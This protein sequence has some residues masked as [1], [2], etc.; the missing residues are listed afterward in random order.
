MN[1][2]L[3]KRVLFMTFAVMGILT[4]NGFAQS[5]NNQLEVEQPN[6][7]FIFIDD[8]GYSD[9]SSY[10]NKEMETPH[11]DRLAKEGIKFTNGYVPAP[12]C[13][14]SR[15]GAMTGQYPARWNIYSFLSQ[16]ENNNRKGMDDYLSL[17]APT[18]ART[19]KEAGYATGHFGKWHMGG[20]RDI[21]DA[22]L[23]TEYGFDQTLVSFEGLGDRILIKDHGLSNASAELGMGNI[24]WAEKWEHTGIWVDST[25]AFIER[26]KDTQPFY[27]NLWPGDVHDPFIPNPEWR[28]KFS[29]FDNDQHKRDFYATLWNLDNEV[30]RLLDKLDELGLS[31]NTLIILMSDNGPTD[32]G[33]YYRDFYWPPGDSDPFYGRK[34][35]L[36]EGGIRVPF[37]ARWPGEIP[38]G[39]TDTSTIINAIDLFP[40]VTKMA[41]VPNH[42]LD[43]DGE[44]MSQALKGVSMKR[45]KPL[46]WEYGRNE[47]F[48]YPG[49]PRF[50]S[51]NLAMRDGDWKLLINDDGSEVELYNLV[52][53]PAETTNLAEENPEKRD[54]L[55]E[56]IFEWRRSLP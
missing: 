7:I 19:M 31:E 54:R 47:H 17:D 26:Y 18:I 9:L 21:N 24:Q 38:A 28:E 40:T 32:W 49:N 37:L 2:H 48:I 50:R 45:K 16:R 33:W 6:I 15:V 5:P 12:I 11:I 20:G 42:H 8:M 39:I 34:W 29:E 52:E 10:G 23:P 25:L 51:P 56:K 46:F 36:Y 14:P 30:G 55:K 35:S 22:P 44:D 3:I 1:K 53:D 13:S 27:I 41:S 4:L 43:F